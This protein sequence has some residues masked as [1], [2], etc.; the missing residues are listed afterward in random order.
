MISAA[1]PGARTVSVS[2]QV[3]LTRSKPAARSRRGHRGGLGVDAAGRWR[4]SPSGPWYTAYIDAITASSTWAVQMLE[5]AFSRRMCCS[6]VCSARR[7]AGR[8]AASTDTPTRRP[9]SE[10]RRASRVA[11]KP[12]W[13]PPKPIGT[14][15]RCAEPTATSAP[16]SPGGRA[17]C[18][19][20]RS[21]AT[22]ARPPPSC[23]ASITGRRSRTTPEVPGMLEQHAEDVLGHQV[24]RRVAHDDVDAERLGPGGDHRDGLG[25][26][27][28]V[29]EERVAVVAGRA[30]GQRH[31]LG[32]R[33]AL[34]EHRGVGDL[35][36]GEVAH[37]RLEVE[38]R[39]EPAL[40]DLGLVG[41]V[42]RVP[43]RVLQHVAEDDAR[44]VGAVVA[45][46][47]SAR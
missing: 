25:V 27:L 9:G 1:W 26:A 31:G 21:V 38:Q 10:R 15:K 24:G 12:A 7:W 8:P 29:D 28:G 43:G 2:N 18:S 3:S 35:H 20:S 4:A 22:T 33:G 39:L 17:G 11:R 30:A 47:R 36:P 44:R 40:A 19:A 41:R 6:R 16:S 37:H 46:R 13:G 32:G 45:R 34:V 14:P 23:T 42:G 5:V